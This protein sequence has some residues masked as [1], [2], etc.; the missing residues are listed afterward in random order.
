[1]SKSRIALGF[2]RHHLERLWHTHSK[3]A[4]VL[5]AAVDIVVVQDIVIAFAV[6]NIVRDTLI[7]VQQDTGIVLDILIAEI[8]RAD[9]IVVDTVETG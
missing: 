7:A 5:E 9:C 8:E 1:M 6:Q 3:S 4:L 2:E